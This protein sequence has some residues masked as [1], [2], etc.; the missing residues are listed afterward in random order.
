MND[1]VAPSLN[2]AAEQ[3][4]ELDMPNAELSAAD[5]LEPQFELE[6]FENPLLFATNY[7]TDDYVIT[8]VHELTLGDILIATL[9]AVL[10]AIKFVSSIVGRR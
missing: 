7:V 10:I 3:P 9:L 4:Q 5:P 8:L 6:S 2:D 1:N